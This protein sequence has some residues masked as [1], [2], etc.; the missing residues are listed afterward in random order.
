MRPIVTDFTRSTS[1]CVQHLGEL[2]KNC[3]TNTGAD[4]CGPKDGVK[5]GRIHSPPWRVTRWQCSL[6]FFDHLL[7]YDS[8]RRGKINAKKT[9]EEW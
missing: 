6:S 5:D 7:K 4:W 2:C 1:V 3:W 9:N 8:H